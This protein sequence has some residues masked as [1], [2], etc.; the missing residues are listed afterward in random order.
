MTHAAASDDL[1]SYIDLIRTRPGMYIGGNAVTLMAFHL[2]GYE[3][4][5]RWKGVEDQ[6]NPPWYDFHEY[7]R[8][9]TGFGESTSGWANMLLDFNSGDEA[10]AL[11]MFFVT[12]DAF[13]A[14][15]EA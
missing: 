5:C 11:D 6:L 4:A 12:F 14:A 3:A 13:R 10:K 2:S 9:K 7:V 8:R 1:Y 15:A